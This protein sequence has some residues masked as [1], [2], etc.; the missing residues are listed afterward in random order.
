M[1]AR[2]HDLAA[3]QQLRDC[4]LSARQPTA[5]FATQPIATGEKERILLYEVIGRIKLW[6]IGGRSAP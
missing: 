2:I 4:G 5:A 1:M 3:C 6:T